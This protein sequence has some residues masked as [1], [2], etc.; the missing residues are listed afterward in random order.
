MANRCRRVRYAATEPLANIT[1]PHR[2]TDVRDSFDAACARINRMHAG[3]VVDS[4]TA[5]TV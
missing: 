2:V 5:A 4:Q 3:M 1:A